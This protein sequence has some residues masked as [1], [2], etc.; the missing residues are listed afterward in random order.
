MF[1]PRDHDFPRRPDTI[2]RHKSRKARIAT[3]TARY[4]GSAARRIS[5]TYALIFLER[6]FSV[7]V[8]HEKR[9][10]QSWPSRAEE[11]RAEADRDRIIHSLGNLTFK[12]WTSSRIWPIRW[13][14]PLRCSKRDGQSALIEL[15]PHILIRPLT[16][17]QGAAEESW[18]ALQMGPRCPSRLG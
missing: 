4:G 13:T 7:S 10:R 17:E 2:P 8:C 15:I 6:F 11:C 18:A 3:G 1:A 16:G 5:E 9:G 12:M 14:R